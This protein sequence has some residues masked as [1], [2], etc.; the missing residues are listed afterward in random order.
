MLFE[1]LDQ[2]MGRGGPGNEV[3]PDGEGACLSG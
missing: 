1:E 3:G 2:V